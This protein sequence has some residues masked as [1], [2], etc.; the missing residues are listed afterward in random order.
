MDLHGL[1][2]MNR[3]TGGMKLEVGTGLPP[4]R[5]FERADYIAARWDFKIN[6]AVRCDKYV[7]EN[8]Q[9]HARLVRTCHQ[10]NRPE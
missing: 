9:T 6:F 1:T 7:S 2:V 5:L 8:F 10:A 3:T 4:R